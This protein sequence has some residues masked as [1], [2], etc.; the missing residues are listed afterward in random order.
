[1]RG[2]GT[3]LRQNRH[4][5]GLGDILRIQAGRRRRHELDDSG[6]TTAAGSDLQ[7]APGSRRLPDKRGHDRTMDKR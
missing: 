1:M 7:Q 2:R 4:H 6:H 5:C 3:W